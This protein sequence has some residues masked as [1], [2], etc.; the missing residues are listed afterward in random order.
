MRAPGESGIVL[1]RYDGVGGY[2]WL[3]IPLVPY[4]YAVERPEDVPL[5]VDGRMVAFSARSSSPEIFEAC[6]DFVKDIIN[7]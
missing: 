6:A 4:L 1:S 3:A 5:F 2:D 7:F